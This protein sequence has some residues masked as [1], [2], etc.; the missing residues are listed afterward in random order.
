MPYSLK[1][2]KKTISGDHSRSWF[3]RVSYWT[4]YEYLFTTA[5]SV[6]A[7]AVH[8][9]SSRCLAKRWCDRLSDGFMLRARLPYRRQG[10]LGTDSRD[11]PNR[12]EPSFHLGVP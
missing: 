7:A 6:A 5:P 9:T 1:T 10:G 11:T 8:P 4:N 12:S 2:M 3:I